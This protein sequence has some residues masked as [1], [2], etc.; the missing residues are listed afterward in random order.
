MSLTELQT[1]LTNAKTA[2][3][4]KDVEIQ[5]Y[6]A[7]KNAQETRLKTLESQVTDKQKQLRTAM[8]QEA[9]ET[10]TAELDALKSQKQACATLIHNITNY[11]QSSART[12][13]SLAS[14]LIITS[15]NNLLL[16]V[17]EDIKDQLKVLTNEQIELLKDFVVISRLLSAH[18]PDSERKTY[19][20]G[21]AFDVLY[22]ELKGADFTVHQEQMMTKYT[23]QA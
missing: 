19:H 14:D 21:C 2:S 11:L 22:G 3:Q 8:S 18:L 1:A 15:Q 10:L 9:A 6:V 20:L 17:Y 16:F 12:E 5:G 4:E 23:T 7:E 13:K